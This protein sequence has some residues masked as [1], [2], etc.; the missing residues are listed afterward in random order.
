[1][2]T[3]HRVEVRLPMVSS[4]SA[5]STGAGRSVDQ[6]GTY[7]AIKSQI[8]VKAQ[9]AKIRK[10]AQR[11]GIR[12]GLPIRECHYHVKNQATILKF[13]SANFRR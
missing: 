6:R 3:F 2:E 13:L 9:P 10:M 11:G 7:S 5:M 4:E 8:V 12:S 1:M